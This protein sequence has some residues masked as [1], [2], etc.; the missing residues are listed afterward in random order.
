MPY[1][2]IIISSD[3]KSIRREPHIAANIPPRK[4]APRVLSR[5]NGRPEDAMVVPNKSHPLAA[6]GAF[7]L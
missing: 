6:W 1:K 7:D 2:L 4:A 3:F 5:L